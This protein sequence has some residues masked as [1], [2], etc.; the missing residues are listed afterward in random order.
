MDVNVSLIGGNVSTEL[1]QSFD[2]LHAQLA[3]K[4]FELEIARKIVWKEMSVLK[5][6]EEPE[7][8]EARIVFEI[9]TSVDTNWYRIQQ[10]WWGRCREMNR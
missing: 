4:G 10:T 3:S 8:L 7:K 2:G 5:M 9:D 1:K 6:A